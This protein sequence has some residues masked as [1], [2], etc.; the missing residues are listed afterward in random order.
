MA[1]ALSRAMRASHSVHRHRSTALAQRVRCL[2]TEQLQRKALPIV[3]PLVAAV[4]PDAP[5]AL[6]LPNLITGARIASTPFLGLLVLHEHYAAALCGCVVVAASDI[7]DGW[8][9][10]RW[11]LETALGSHLDPLADKLFI[12]TMC[13]SLAAVGALDGRLAAVVVAR[14]VALV[15]GTGVALWQQAR[16]SGAQTPA[17]VF[18]ALVRQPLWVRPSALSKFNT[19]AQVTLV[20]EALLTAICGWPGAGATQLLSAAVLLSTCASAAAYA[21]ALAPLLRK[22]PG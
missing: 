9:A 2:A 4:Q 7:A 1:L 16:A 15:T 14:D 11:A 20:G 13:V 22:K 17:D 10:R 6:N 21:P 5:S 18:R 8:I 12:G 19:A 3:A